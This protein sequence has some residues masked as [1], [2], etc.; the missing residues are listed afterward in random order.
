MT[1]ACEIIFF[2]NT[3]RSF[4]F[5]SSSCL[6]FLILSICVLCVSIWRCQPWWWV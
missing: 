3:F 6:H 5:L 2:C 1:P 4:V